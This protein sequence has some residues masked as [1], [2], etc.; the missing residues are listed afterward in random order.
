MGKAKRKPT[1]KAKRAYFELIRKGFRRTRNALLKH[2]PGYVQE[3]EAH[4]R[5]D[6]K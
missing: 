1:L 2:D 6:R 3:V 4:N 5:S